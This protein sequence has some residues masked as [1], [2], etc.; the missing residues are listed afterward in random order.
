MYLNE[1]S[2]RA[3]ALD[4]LELFKESVQENDAYIVDLNTSQLSKGK[5]STDN[6][7]DTYASAN[8]AQF[9]S[10]MGSQAPQGIPDLKLTGEFYSGFEVKADESGMNISSTDPKSPKLKAQYGDDIFGLT[11]KSR[12]DLK[13]VLLET[14][15]NKI[16]NGLLRT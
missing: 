13:T 3:S 6:N 12:A 10:A 2:R 7:L 5:D 16:R 11:D 14:Y 1:L 15:L 9:K 4:P 8:Y